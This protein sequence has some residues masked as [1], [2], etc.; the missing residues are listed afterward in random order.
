MRGPQ[1]KQE[2]S[3]IKNDERNPDILDESY[4]YSSGDQRKREVKQEEKR[5]FSM[6]ESQEY[7][8]PPIIDN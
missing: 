5:K 3:S 6:Q 2:K 4:S 1:E 7:N 8:I